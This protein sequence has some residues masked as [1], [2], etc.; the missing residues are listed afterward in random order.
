MNA[1]LTDILVRKPDTV[2]IEAF[3]GIQLLSKYGIE[4]LE[5]I[6]AVRGVCMVNNIPCEKR[7]PASR[8]LMEIEAKA[9]LDERRRRMG[10]TFSYTVHEV[11][12]LAH[13]L[14]WERVVE[15]R[16]RSKVKSL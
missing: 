4:T 3:I 1:I 12:A 8:K 14:S 15:R 16:L 6:G 10:P 5:L 2:V 13:L 9:L 7:T 11:S